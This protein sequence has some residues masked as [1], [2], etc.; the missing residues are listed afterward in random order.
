MHEPFDV[1]LDSIFAEAELEAG[2]P[3]AW[4]AAHN[5]LAMVSPAFVVKKQKPPRWT[6]QDDKFLR[7][8]LGVLTPEEIA[9]RLGRSTN[10]IKIR[11]VRQQFAAASKRPG[12][13][14]GRQVADILG[15]DI[16][17]VMALFERGLIPLRRL[18]G[19]RGI[20]AMR[21]ISLYCWAV[22]PEHWP[23]FIRSVW[24]TERIADPHLRRLIER[25]KQRW[26]DEWWTPGQVAAYHQRFTRASSA[27]RGDPPGDGVHHTDVNRYIHHG[28]LK[29]TKWNNWL[30]KRSEAT[31]PDL[32]FHKGKGAGMAPYVEAQWTPGAD[33]YIL[34]AKG[35]GLIWAEIARRM[36][37]DERSV[38]HRGRVL[39]KRMVV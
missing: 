25:Q 26:G 21:Q 12:W 8:S 27:R 9:A 14:T 11:Q 20:M 22:N 38:G 6:T 5:P 1:Q 4:V 35:E 2:L 39:L 13:L 10:A 17:N 3:A 31:R 18:P 28:R 30:I 7:E 34:R 16:H 33:A 32:K 37:R 15:V 23:Y 19:E 36:K 29:A 24:A